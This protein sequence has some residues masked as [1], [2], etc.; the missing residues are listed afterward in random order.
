LFRPSRRVGYLGRKRS[1][2]AEQESHLRPDSSLQLQPH[3]SS[4]LTAAGCSIL[5]SI[6]LLYKGPRIETELTSTTML[7]LSTRRSVARQ[8][9]RLATAS[10]GASAI[11]RSRAENPL[12]SL[13]SCRDFQSTPSTAAF[14]PTWMPMRVKTP[15]VEALNKSRETAQ[16]GQTEA[17]RAKADLT[18]KKMSDSY[19]SAV[20]N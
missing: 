18:P 15:W 19:Y 1:S 10:S 11:L 20:S 6:T 3:R 17:P 13:I 9:N 4:L 7:S 8:S 2:E 14:R 16:Q 5:T 12:Q